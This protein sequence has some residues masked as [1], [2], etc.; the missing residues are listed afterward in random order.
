[1]GANALLKTQDAYLLEHNSVAGRDKMW[2]NN[3]DGEGT[4]WLGA[5]LMLIRDKLKKSDGW[6]GAIGKLL[7]LETGEFTSAAAQNQWQDVV[8]QATSA[9]VAELKKRKLYQSGPKCMKAG[10]GKPT[11]NGAAYE[12]C[13]KACKTSNFMSGFGMGNSSAQPSQPSSNSPAMN[14]SVNFNAG[15]PVVVGKPL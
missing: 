9:L 7:S 11:W 15:V 14:P 3:N 5:Q 13:S 8:R 6:T 1:M 12:Y 10:C 4:N 2:S